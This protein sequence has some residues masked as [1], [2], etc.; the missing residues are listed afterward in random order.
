MTSDSNKNSIAALTLA[1]IGIVYGDIGTS[2]LYTMKEVF[3]KHHGLSPVPVNVLGVVSLILWGL[4]IVISLKYVTLVLRADNR[5]EG[6]IMAM[7]ALALSSVTQKSRWYYPVMLL[8]MVGAGLFFGDGVITPAIS[9]LSA[10][11]GL[12]VAAPALKPYVIPVTLAVLVALYLLQRRGTAGIGK[13]FGPIVLV[14]FITLAAMGVANIAK[15]PVILIAFNPLH[16]LGFLIHNGW[17]AFVALGAVVLAL[18]GAEALYADMGHFGKKTVRL[19][20]FSIVAPALALNYLGQGALLLS[21][22][23]A[24]SNPFFLQLGPWSVYPLVVLS[25]M[26]TVIASQATISG[27]FSVTQQAIALGFLPRMRILQTSESHK[28]QIY[29]PLVNWLQLTAVILAVVGFG[30]SSNLASAYGIAA[31]ATMLTTTLLTF[32]VVRFGWKFPLLLS[33][34]ATGFFLTI[35]VALFSSTSLKIISG[36]WFTLTISALMVMLMLTWRRGRELV[37]QSLQRQLIPLDDFLQSLF[38]NPPLRV[39]GTAVFFRAEGDGVP[40]ALLHNLLHNQVLHERTIFLTVYATDIPRVPDRERIKVVPHGHNCYQVNVYYG[41]SDERDIP[42]ALQ[43]GRHAGL[44][45]DPMQTSFFIARQTVLAT[46][47]AGM[48]LWREALYS[49]MSRNAR[50]AADY[51]KIPPNRVIELGAQVEI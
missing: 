45:I 39:P 10:I 35:D 6:G 19:A 43:E 25:T 38:I 31:T 13:W 30:S 4:I 3:A 28:G 36:G 29:I 2:P 23:A 22:P 46:P 51:F 14:W 26:A 1:A 37:F 9:V 47:K 21:N 20:W 24:V 44:S 12:E 7:T 32:F 42:R 8:G 18:T 27:A 15:N 33:V 49:A 11:E 34:A 16:A 48:A 41:F 50:D 17:L 5:G 40:H